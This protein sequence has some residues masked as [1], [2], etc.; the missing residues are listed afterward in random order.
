[1]GSTASASTVAKAYLNAASTLANTADEVNSAC[2]CSRPRVDPGNIVLASSPRVEIAEQEFDAESVRTMDEIPV[3][4]ELQ[5]GDEHIIPRGKR[6]SI[7]SCT[8]FM[9]C[10]RSSGKP[11]IPMHQYIPGRSTVSVVVMRHA[12]RLDHAEPSVWLRSPSAQKYPFDCPI[13]EKGRKHAAAV[14]NIFPER[15]SHQLSLVVTSPYMRCIGTAVEVCRALRLPMCIDEELGEVY[16][17]ACFGDWEEPGPARRS[18]KEVINLLPEDV[19]LIGLPAGEVHGF[20]GE[21]PKWGESIESARLRMV[22]RV[23]QYAERAARLGG[24]AFV[25]VTH[26]D[27]VA[28][29]LALALAGQPGAPEGRI[30]EKVHYCGY[31]VLARNP[32]ISGPDVGLMDEEARWKVEYGL[33]VVSQVGWRHFDDDGVQQFDQTPLKEERKALNVQRQARRQATMVSKNRSFREKSE[34]AL[35]FQQF[36]GEKIH[37]NSCYRSQIPNSRWLVHVS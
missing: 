14:A 34:E 19:R 8:E 23:E 3:F 37:P 6:G 28:A 11:C 10:R 9:S 17:P 12:E 18:A 24:A 31:T 7:L 21:A 30:V 4:E 32:E 15:C 16:G 29:C 33:A 25:L 35:G 20:V 2:S 27:C 22:G 36:V 26:A 1:M 13:T 5:D